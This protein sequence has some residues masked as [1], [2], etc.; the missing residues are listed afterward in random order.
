MAGWLTTEQKLLLMPKLLKIVN[1]AGD[2]IPLKPNYCQQYTLENEGDK[3][4]ILKYRQGGLSTIKLGDQ[5]LDC[6]VPNPKTGRSNITAVIFSYD[7]ES[8]QR[9]LGKVETMYENLPNPKPYMGRD[10]T[11]LKTFPELGSRLY[12]GT[13]GARVAGLGDTVNRAHLSEFAYWSPTNARR[14]KEGLEQAVP[15]GDK[16]TIENT[17]NGEGGEFYDMWHDPNCP[18]RKIFLPWYWHEEYSLGRD[19]PR[20][21]NLQYFTMRPEDKG[22][23]EFSQEE[24]ELVS[25]FALTED[26]IRWRRMKV[27]ETKEMFPQWYP[28]DPVTCFVASGGSIFSA[29]VLKHMARFTCEPLKAEDGLKRWELPMFGEKYIIGVDSADPDPANP[30]TGGD[31]CVAIVVSSRFRHVATLRGQWPPVEFA[32]RVARLA[33]MYNG[34]YIVP[35]RNSIGTAV[36]VALEEV[37]RYP[38]IYKTGERTGW[39]SNKATKRQLVGVLEDVIN[40]SVLYTRD[41][42]LLSELRIFRKIGNK[43]MAKEGSHDDLVIAL[44]LALLGIDEI[45]RGSMSVVGKKKASTGYGSRRKA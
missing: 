29:D 23:L 14:I 12:I 11:H 38:Y 26:Q 5:F 41:N 3:T 32:Y 10:S 9:L 18:Y 19:D 7:D 39:M 31:F 33:E 20:L 22:E 6:I 1:K 42:E 36:C 16:I 8:T 2:L 25:A 37:E 13:A 30:K 44:G 40:S 15:M 17:A 4:Q 24:I 28:E 21:E 45:P 27:A 34:A 43:F 35:E